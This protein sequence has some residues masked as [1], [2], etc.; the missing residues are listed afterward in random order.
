MQPSP[1]QLAMAK[2]DRQIAALQKKRAEL[3]TTDLPALAELRKLA[4]LPS[5][6]PNRKSRNKL[7]IIGRVIKILKDDPEARHGL[8]SAMLHQRLLRERPDLSFDALRS[9]LS[10]AKKEGR[11]G[12]HPQHQLWRLPSQTRDSA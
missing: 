7:E 3:A 4:L 12:H 6:K 5:E 8:T 11:L 2:L 1:Y 10:R 9:H